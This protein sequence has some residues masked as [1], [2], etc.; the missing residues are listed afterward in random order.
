[1]HN[2]IFHRTTLFHRCHNM[3]FIFKVRAH[4]EELHQNLAQFVL[5]HHNNDPYVNSTLILSKVDEN[6]FSNA[7]NINIQT[8][9]N[10]SPKEMHT[11]HLNLLLCK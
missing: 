6:I 3:S 7:R 1:M 4:F 10:F 2:N 8:E 5:L 9:A 11:K